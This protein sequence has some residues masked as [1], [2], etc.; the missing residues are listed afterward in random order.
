MC[1]YVSVCVPCGDEGRG[2]PLKLDHRCCEF[3]S[4]SHPGEDGWMGKRLVLHLGAR[5]MKLKP[6]IL[7][8]GAQ[9]PPGDS[10]GRG[11]VPRAVDMTDRYLRC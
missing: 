6:S 11:T 10:G 1:V 9:A 7:L 8:L 4:F 2:R 3:T 5:L